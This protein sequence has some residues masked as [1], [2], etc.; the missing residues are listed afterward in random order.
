MS[1]LFRGPLLAALAALALVADGRALA[2]PVIGRCVTAE[3]PARIDAVELPDGTV[4]SEGSIRLCFSHRLSP[5]AGLHETQVGAAPG[6]LY[7]SRVETIE[8]ELGPPYVALARAG[9][10]RW[11]LEGYAVPTGRGMVAFHLRPVPADS[12]TASLHA[13]VTAAFTR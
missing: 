5:V 4:A 12:A 11:R 10:G 1:R 6:G 9:D 2:A 3:L 8:A 7:V 13:F